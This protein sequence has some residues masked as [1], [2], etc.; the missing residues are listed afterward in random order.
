MLDVIDQTRTLATAVPSSLSWKMQR[1][2]ASSVP[3]RPMIS[4]THRDVSAYVQDFFFHA[5]MI[6]HFF[7]IN[8]GSE[9]MVA[10]RLYNFQGDQ[11]SVYVRTLLQS[12]LSQGDKLLN[13]PGTREVLLNDMCKLVLPIDSATL[14]SVNDTG[15]R[16]EEHLQLFQAVESF[17]E[18]V[19]SS[20]LNLIRVLCLNRCRLRRS[21]CHAVAEWDQIQADAEETDALVQ[22]LAAEEPARYP[23]QGTLTYQYPLSSWVY[24]YKLVQMEL[25]IQMGF[26]LRVY[27]VEEMYQMYWYLSHI[28]SIHLSHLD[29]VG[30]FVR[31]HREQG[32]IRLGTAGEAEV[33]DT[34]RRL[35]QI[36][37]EVKATEAFAGALHR[38]YLVIWRHSAHHQYHKKRYSSDQ[39]R[40]ELRMRPFFSVSVPEAMSFEVFLAAT[41]LETQSDRKLLADS[42]RYLTLA[43]RGWDEAR[44]RG[45]RD[46]TT[47]VGGTQSERGFF[48]QL[49]SRDMTQILKACI[50]TGVAIATLSTRLTTGPDAC[51]PKLPNL[52]IELPSPGQHDCWHNW[53][54]VPRILQ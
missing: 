43:K 24:H 49:W 21:L 45:W 20:F 29:R 48:D 3:P 6:R 46:Q 36:F 37:G 39:M 5:S 15:N 17:L 35:L 7:D 16:A 26:E 34:L 40:Y 41:K 33:G 27:A 50:G 51:G 18:R 13:K 42:E 8:S 54:L 44:K 32:T 14:R 10:Y 2:L 30:F 47:S 31:R 19:C 11:H 28:C 4:N 9:L 12:F 23:D 22:E 38:L 53:W 1:T 52:K 25:L